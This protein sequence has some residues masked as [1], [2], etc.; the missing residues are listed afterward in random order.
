MANTQQR[1]I[2]KEDKRRKNN[3]NYFNPELETK[4]SKKFNEEHIN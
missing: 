4:S 3:A 2:D 1:L